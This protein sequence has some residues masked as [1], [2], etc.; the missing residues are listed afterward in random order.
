MQQLTAREI[1][2]M[3]LSEVPERLSVPKT[4]VR[5]ALT[6]LLRTW[7]PDVSTDPRAEE[8]FEHVVSLRDRQANSGKVANADLGERILKTRSGH[9]I[10]TVPLSSTTV[11]QGEVFVG[12]ESYAML[13]GSDFSDMAQ[14]EL[15]AIEGFRF[16]NQAMRDQ[17]SFS[18]PDL[19]RK[20]DLE[21]GGGLVVVRKTAEEILL[22]DVLRL[23]GA[24]PDKHLAWI[25][26]GLLNIT[27]WLEYAAL[28]HGAISTEHVLVDPVKHSVRLAGGWCFATSVG[29]RPVALPGRT[30]DL[31]PRMGIPGTPAETTLDRELVRQTIREAAGDPRGTNGG[32]AALPEK[33]SRWLQM[34]PTAKAVDDYSRWQAAL[35]AAWGPRTFVKWDLRAA[36]IYG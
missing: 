35:E 2:D 27:A 12:R 32:V 33:M 34:A 26:S 16:A 29:E 9:R 24:I 7:H 28:V 19:V 25:A 20:E 14:A 23:R 36:S 1:L 31:M 5:K 18:L 22:S 13:F 17:M 6:K 15:R 11:D 3:T 10:R 21:D 8:V 4:D 30:L